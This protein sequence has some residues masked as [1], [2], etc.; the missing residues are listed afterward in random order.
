M[1][2]L[3]HDLTHYTAFESLKLNKLA[4]IITNIPTCVPSALAF[5]KYH[6]DHHLYM[7]QPDKD[8]D[9]PS[10][11][12]IRMISTHPILKFFFVLF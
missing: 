5:A 7:G 9:L 6:A 1:Q 2:V 8:A 4:A 3:V 10:E 11:I 12:E